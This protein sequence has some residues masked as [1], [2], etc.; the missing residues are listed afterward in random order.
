MTILEL[1]LGA[2]NA[3]GA[4]ASII[5]GIDF[6][7][8][9]F[10][11][12]TAEDL[13]KKSFV[14]AVKQNAPRLAHFTKT[15]NPET[16][17]VDSNTLDDVITSLKDIDISTLTLLEKNGKLIKITALFSKCIILPGHQLT[18]KELEQEIL[19]RC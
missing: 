6:V 12:S 17:D 11:E 16:V 9:R 5:G 13:F 3:V 19:P 15:R 10:S 14:N 4:S 8:R 2:Y 1:A 7:L 18:T